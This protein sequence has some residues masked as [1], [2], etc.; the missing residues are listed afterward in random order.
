MKIYE[1]M[2]W[3][4]MAVITIAAFFGTYY[5]DIS[6]PI[7]AL[8]WIGWL[9]STLGLSLFTTQGRQVVSFGKEAKIE[10]QKV[11]WPARKETMQFTWI[12]FLFVIILGLFLWLVDSGLAWLL[13]GVI[14]GKGS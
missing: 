8:V 3:L 1:L 10:L 2:S 14:L 11:V 12:V 4:G 5:F 13:Y 9:V 7:K 6:G